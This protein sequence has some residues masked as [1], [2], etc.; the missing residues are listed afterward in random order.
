MFKRTQTQKPATLPSDVYKETNKLFGSLCRLVG[1]K[2]TKGEP[3]GK[4][5]ETIDGL[6]APVSD[7]FRRHEHP[8]IQHEASAALRGTRLAALGGRGRGVGQILEQRTAR[9]GCRF[10]A[11]SYTTNVITNEWPGGDFRF[12]GNQQEVV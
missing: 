8:G 12:K 1:P 4:Q 6:L 2:E 10:K 5:K 3:N 7:L 9:V 11:T